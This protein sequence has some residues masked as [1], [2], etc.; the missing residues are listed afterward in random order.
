MTQSPVVCPISWCETER[1]SVWGRSPGG[2]VLVTLINFAGVRLSSTPRDPN[3]GWR[4]HEVVAVADVDVSAGGGG[5]RSQHFVERLAR[6]MRAVLGT[7]VLLA[8]VGRAAALATSSPLTGVRTSRVGVAPSWEGGL[9]HS[10]TRPTSPSERQLLAP[11]LASFF[12]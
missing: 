10:A 4:L 9:A 8:I 1:R 12:S 5:S 3:E 7:A 2:Q 11:F 6:H